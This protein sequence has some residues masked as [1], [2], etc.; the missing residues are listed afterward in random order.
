MFIATI[1][2]RKMPYLQKLSPESPV[3]GVSLWQDF[4]PELI[5][6]WQKLHVRTWGSRALIELEKFLRRIRLFFSSVDRLSDTLIKKVRRAHRESVV[7]QQKA[8]EEVKESL[9]TM[10]VAPLVSN[11][12]V[13]GS[14][15]DTA[16]LKQREQETIVA[17][18]QDPK[19]EELYVRLGDLYLELKNYSDAR[20]SYQAALKIKPND[21]KV[22]E[23]LI[24]ALEH[25]SQSKKETDPALE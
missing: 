23:K 11:I 18:A 15:E 4:F 14:K 24:I 20:E 1:I 6:G 7:A 8:A 12:H 22:A 21:Q 25:L 2:W 13:K 5:N 3:V 16:V 10:P 9:P 19:N 17:I